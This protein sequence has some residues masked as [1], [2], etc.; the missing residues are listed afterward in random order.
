MTKILIVE[1]EEHLLVTLAYNLRKAGYIVESAA[2]GPTAVAR[3]TIEPADLV[4]LDVMLPGFDGFEVCRRLRSRS[5]VPILMLTAR[6]DEID[7]VVGL[8]LGA[9][10]YI[11]KPFRMRELLARIGAALRR[12][13]PSAVLPA[14]YQLVSGDIV[15]DASAFQLTRGGRVLTLKP[16]AFALLQF[17]MQHPGL[18]FSRDQ[19]L[20]QLWNDPFIGDP[21]TVDVHIRWIREQIEDDPSHPIRIRTIRNVGYQFVG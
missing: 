4:L 20:Q 1:D 3:F 2:D 10:D 7:V 5:T 6:T 15:L 9:D 21:R 18:V 13:A 16:R 17:L 8:E 12:S 14:T 19:L 11:V